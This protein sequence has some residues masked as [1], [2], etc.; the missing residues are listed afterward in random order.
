MKKEDILATLNALPL[1]E[2]LRFVHE[3]FGSDAVFTTSLGKEDQV[4]TH[5]LRTSDNAATIITLDTGRLFPETYD[6]LATTNARYNDAVKLIFPDTKSV[7]KLVTNQGING[8]YNSIENRKNCCFVRKIEP[9]KRALADKKLWIT[10]LR[11]SQSANRNN[12]EK[13]SWDEQFNILKYNPLIEYSSEEI[14]ALI[15]RYSIPIN[16][17]H[18]Q[19]YVSI[20]CAPCTRAISPGEDERAGRWWWESSQKECGLHATTTQNQHA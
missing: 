5:Y 16:P 18:K 20:G 9:L 11:A 1:E 12:F 8:F 19:G 14:D 7:E 6:L 3:T 10:G 13:A 4:L 15:Q 2:G 17:L